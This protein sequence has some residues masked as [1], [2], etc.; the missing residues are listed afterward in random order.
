[1]NVEYDPFEEETPV[2]VAATEVVPDAAPEGGGIVTA[3]EF[4]ELA[5]DVGAVS[6]SDYDPFEEID[7]ES[8]RAAQ[9]VTAYDP[10][11]TA[12]IRDFSRE[13]GLSRVEAE[14]FLSDLQERRKREMAKTVIDQTPGLDSFLNGIPQ[15]APLFQNDL[16]RLS[17]VSR[18]FSEYPTGG[19]IEVNPYGDAAFDPYGDRRA[20]AVPMDESTGNEALDRQVSYMRNGW[21]TLF[22]GDI[23]RGFDAGVASVRQGALWDRAARGEVDRN[24]PA[25]K[26]ENDAYQAELDR[27]TAEP[28]NCAAL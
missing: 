25:F 4:A 10:Q 23:E 27:A 2:E 8:K 21:E 14:R 24:S 13:Y 22:H 15:D 26:E 9:A 1:M 20:D 18:L 19:Q 17:T 12:E 5:P 16:G 7:Q 28:A 11:K 3:E 6:F